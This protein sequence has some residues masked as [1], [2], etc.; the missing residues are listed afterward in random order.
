LSGV[1]GRNWRAA[2]LLAALVAAGPARA[3]GFFGPRTAAAFQP[4]VD[5]YLHLADGVR[6]QLQVLDY[7]VPDQQNN[8]VTVALFASW[9]VA[10]VLRELL[11][12][13]R[14]KTHVVDARVGVLYNATTDPGTAGPGN[15]WTL[16]AE[17]TPRA[18]LPLGVLASLRNRVSFNWG[19]DPASG[20][21]FLYRLRPQLEREFPA[22]GVPITP[23]VNAEVVWQSPPAMWTQFRIQGGLQVGFDLLARGQTLEV[24]Y[25]VITSLQ[26]GRSW[27]PQLGVI[28]SSYF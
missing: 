13:D 15:L 16:Q 5:A 21:Y 9:L 23:Y 24:N 4:E 27:N 14:A 12:P 8:Q 18:N 7:L 10:D 11:S 17:V 26:P 2:A 1:N 20:F 25:E 28:L 22:W 6:I 3:Q 19:V